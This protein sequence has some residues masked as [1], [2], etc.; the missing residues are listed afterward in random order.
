M[1]KA[2]YRRKIRDAMKSLGV[3]RSEFDTAISQLAEL[4]ESRDITAER[5]EISGGLP[6]ITHVNKSGASNLV[7]NPILCVMDKMDEMI[8]KYMSE[9]GLTPRG[10]LR[11]DK[12]GLKSRP[13]AS[14]LEGFLNDFV[15]GNAK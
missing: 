6:V 5:Y 3:Y 2:T 12:K 13:S 15:G 4:K 9:L 8:L 10:L 1:T 11:L 14:K 7:K